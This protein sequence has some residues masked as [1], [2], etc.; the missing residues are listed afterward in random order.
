M[1]ID[2]S[3]TSYAIQANS[4]FMNVDLQVQNVNLNTLLIQLPSGNNA[5][6]FFAVDKPR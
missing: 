3:M 5:A 2:G 4:A 6:T 1:S